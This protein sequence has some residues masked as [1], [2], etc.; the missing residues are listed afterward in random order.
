MIYDI[1]LLVIGY[2]KIVIDNGL[3]KVKAQNELGGTKLDKQE[4][5]LIS[6][7]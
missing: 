7:K 1:K 4:K 6:L 5:A 2:K 3:I